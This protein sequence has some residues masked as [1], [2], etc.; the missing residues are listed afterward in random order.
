MECLNS[1]TL[2]DQFDAIFLQRVDEPCYKFDAVV[3]LSF[4]S[5]TELSA[6]A[7]EINGRRV[8]FAERIFK[9]LREGLT[10]RVSLIHISY[11]GE[12]PFAIRGARKGTKPKRR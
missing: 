7:P 4:P 8:A 12:Q 6:M 2:A 10:D 3:R 9:T 5:E 11:E 1:S